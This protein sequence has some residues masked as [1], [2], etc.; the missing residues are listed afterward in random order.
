MVLTDNENV[1]ENV[2]VREPFGT[3]DHYII[4][5][6][7]ICNVE[8]KAIEVNYRYRDYKCG[9]YNEMTGRL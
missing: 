9:I 4:Q 2:V 6:D 1:V 3:S 7:L 5:F 8:P